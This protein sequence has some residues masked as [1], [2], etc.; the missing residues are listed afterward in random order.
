MT[1]TIQDM[2]LQDDAAEMRLQALEWVHSPGPI[3]RLATYMICLL[4][5][6]ERLLAAMLKSTYNPAVPAREARQRRHRR[7][8]FRGYDKQRELTRPIH[9]TTRTRK[10]RPMPMPISDKEVEE[11][12]TR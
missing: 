4:D 6:R 7:T 10:L 12:V 8:E 2:I 9:A 5:D 11:A 1:S 3:A